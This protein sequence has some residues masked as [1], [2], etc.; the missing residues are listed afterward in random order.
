MLKIFN[1]NFLYTTFFFV[2]PL[3]IALT[4][5]VHFNDLGIWTA[6]GM[7]SIRTGHLVTIDTF[8]ILPTVEMIYPAWGISLVYGAI[9]LA[10][11]ENGIA[12]LNLFHKLVLVC[13]LLRVYSLH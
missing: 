9:N 6:L 5:P 8:S 7:E 10:A 12:W 4:F 2:Y 3:I 1:R 11:N 13:F